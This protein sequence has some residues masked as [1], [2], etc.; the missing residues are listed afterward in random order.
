MSRALTVLLL[1]L[2]MLLVPA[3]SLGQ[4]S[5]RMS[6]SEKAVWIKLFSDMKDD[7]EDGSD[8]REVAETALAAL[9]LTRDGS[10]Y[11]GDVWVWWWDYHYVSADGVRRGWHDAD[12]PVP[13]YPGMH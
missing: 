6:S 10:Q 2:A 7:S 9:V 8:C 3:P 12:N 1:T 5:R 4:T 11:N 13:G